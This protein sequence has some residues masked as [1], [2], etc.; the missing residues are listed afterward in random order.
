MN[1]R[2]Q[3]GREQ[4][5]KDQRSEKDG[6]AA[7]AA[8]PQKPGA[9]HERAPGESTPKDGKGVTPVPMVSKPGGGSG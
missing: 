9:G 3:G 7:Q 8:P 5:T 4:P 6:M 2:K 1:E